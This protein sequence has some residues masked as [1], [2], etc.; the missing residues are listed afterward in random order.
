MEANKPAWLEL[1]TTDPAGAREFYKKVFGW[2]IEV[3]PDPQY[4]GYA[5]AY[6]GDEGVAGIG[7]KRPGDS[8]PSNWSIYIGTESAD[9]TAKKVKAAGGTVVMEPF[10]VPAQ[11]RMVVFQDPSGAFVSAWQAK[12]HQGFKSGKE[13]QYGWAELSAR[14]LEKTLPFYRSVFGWDAKTS[15]AGDKGEPPYTEFQVG[16]ESVA[17]A[18]EM[19]PMVPQQVPSYWMPYF[20]AA[21]VDATFKKVI[22]AGG[23]EMVAPSDFPGGRFAIVMDPQGAA[24]GLVRSE[25]R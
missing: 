20:N 11:G 23:K 5:L 17:G 18:M 3:S 10:D 13:A 6:T 1:S 22:D 21:E 25:P 9:E 16:K 14:G 2:K 19:P 4:G 24:F 7:G 12:A 15:P 8:S